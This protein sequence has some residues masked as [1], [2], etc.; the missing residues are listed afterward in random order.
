MKARQAKDGTVTVELAPGEVPE[1]RRALVLCGRDDNLSPDVTAPVHELSC[2]LQEALASEELVACLDAAQEETPVREEK[3]KRTD[4]KRQ[5]SR[6][7]FLVEALSV[8]DEK[9]SLASEGTKRSLARL[10]DLEDDARRF[11]EATCRAFS[12]RASREDLSFV[13]ELL[14]VEER[15]RRVL[16]TL[17]RVRIDAP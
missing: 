8:T 11:W 7:K 2:I 6:T 12:S 9:R 13:V 17:S 15:P 1:L 16:R 10:F 3:K 5:P 4:A 14:E